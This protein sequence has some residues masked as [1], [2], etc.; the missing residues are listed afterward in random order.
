MAIVTVNE[1]VA[2]LLAPSVAVH[3]TVVIPARKEEPEAG[4]QMTGT[5]PLTRS[6]AVGAGQPTGV[7]AAAD[8][9]AI[10]EGMLLIIGAVVS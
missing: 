9:V 1:A 5:F 3:C 4:A 8:W 2:V 7:D 10:G 6:E